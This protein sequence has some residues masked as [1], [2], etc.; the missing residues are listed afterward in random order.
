[1]QFLEG[2]AAFGGG[3]GGGYGGDLQRHVLGDA[4]QDAFQV[5]VRAAL[6]EDQMTLHVEGGQFGGAGAEAGEGFARG[7]VGLFDH[8]GVD[9]ALDHTLEGTGAADDLGEQRLARDG[10]RRIGGGRRNGRRQGDI[11][12]GEQQG[13]RQGDAAGH[14]KPHIVG[15]IADSALN[16]L[17]PEP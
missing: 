4:A 6:L 12:V 15:R 8:P 16:R 13:D 11:G 7:E 3:G 17:T 10:D 14:G 1:M 5:A 9:P 2:E